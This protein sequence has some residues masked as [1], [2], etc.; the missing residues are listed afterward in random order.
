MRW[1][2]CDF[3]PQLGDNF[4]GLLYLKALAAH[5]PEVELVCW[6]TPELHGQ[7]SE[8]L[9]DLTFITEWLIYPRSPQ[10]SYRLNHQILARV[11]SRGLEF[12]LENLPPGTGPDGPAYDKIIPTAEPWFTAKLLAGQP[13]DAP[14]PLNQGEFLGNLLSIPD[15]EAADQ[16][17]VFGQALPRGDHFCLGLCRPEAD[18]PKQPARR[19]VEQVWLAVEAS[20]QEVHALDYQDW[21]DPP[22]LPR[23]H[24]W[25][26]RSLAE[27][28]N[29]LNT[30]VRFIGVDGGLTHFA[31][32]CGCPTTAFY[33]SR[34]PQH[35]FRVGPYPRLDHTYHHK[36]AEFLSEVRSA[37]G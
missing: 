14:D 30:A 34:D 2:V 31:A 4:R 6:I 32:A 22:A 28:V 23:I 37:V 33:G 24:D 3:G 26:S 27:K 10:E 8:L 9:P 12:R 21:F 35:G 19:L 7:L 36:F 1:L 29:V 11:L 20:G 13:L 16:L 15:Q 18:D 17:P 25:R 5:W